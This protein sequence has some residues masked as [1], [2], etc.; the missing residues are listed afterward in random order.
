MPSKWI[1]LITGLLAG[2][3]TY[4]LVSGDRLGVVG[5]VTLVGT[6]AVVWLGLDYLTDKFRQ[7]RA[8]GDLA[9]DDAA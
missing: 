5:V 1:N 8:G 7:R 3:L 6:F 4:V 2:L 9:S